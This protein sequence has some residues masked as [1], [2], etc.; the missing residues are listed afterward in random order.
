MT[1]DEKEVMKSWDKED[2]LV[3]QLL[4]QRLPDKVSMEVFDL[5]TTKA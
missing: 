1:S 3:H 5:K 4:T 2:K